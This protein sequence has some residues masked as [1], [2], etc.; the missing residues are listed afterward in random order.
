[1]YTFEQLKSKGESKNINNS[2]DKEIQIS[3]TIELVSQITYSSNKINEG[4]ND[5]NNI[6]DKEK[7]NKKRRQ[8]P[9]NKGTKQFNKDDKSIKELDIAQKL[10]LYICFLRIP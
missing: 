5:N 9:N 3:N 1:M 10:S 8:E 4:N 7:I 2:N 6:F